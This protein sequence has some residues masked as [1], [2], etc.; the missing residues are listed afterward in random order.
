MA[1]DKVPGSHFLGFIK[2]VAISEEFYKNRPIICSKKGSIDFCHFSSK[3]TS[4]HRCPRSSDNSSRQQV[5]RQCRTQPDANPSH[6]TSFSAFPH[7]SFTDAPPVPPSP[8]QWCHG[9]CCAGVPCETSR[10]CFSS[11]GVLP[12]PAACCLAQFPTSL[13]VNAVLTVRFHYKPWGGFTK[14]P[15]CKDIP[16]LFR[17]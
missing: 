14:M 9:M 13:C 12:S 4:S 11:A 7:C 16:S 17:C 3:K 1:L 5:G 10:L 2:R 8:Q 15:R 6:F